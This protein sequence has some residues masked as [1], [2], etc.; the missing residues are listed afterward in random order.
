MT[1]PL[2]MRVWM[3]LAAAIAAAL[4]PTPAVAQG[5]PP[6]D[7]LPGQVIVRYEA[8][9]SKAER[10]DA[11]E[12]S[13]TEAIAGL[14]MP[15][16]QLV[17]ITD[18][19]S[20]AATL[21]QLEAQPG[22]AY[23]EPN[24]LSRPA[25]LP[26]DPEFLNGNQ[27]GLFNDGQTVNGEPG[28]PNADIS[29][30]AAWNLTTGVSS[31][32]VAVMDTGA[33]LQHPDLVDE[34]WT[35]P[36][37]GITHGHDFIGDGYN[38]TPGSINPDSDPRDLDGHGT[39]VSGIALA[40][41]NN[42][43]GITGVS[44]RAALMSLRICGAYD[45]GCPDSALVQAINYA[46]DHGARVVNGS[47]AG[48]VPNLAVSDALESH[49]GTLYVFA[50]GNGDTSGNGVN[51]DLVPNYPCNSDQGPGYAA[52][53]VICVAATDQSDRRADFSNYGASAVDLGAPGVNIFSA[54]SQRAFLSDDFESG[55]GQWTNT[56]G[57][58]WSLVNEAPLNQPP[59]T[60]ANNGVSD[61]PGGDYAAGV[62]NEVT[63][64]AVT[65]P[66]GYSS[67]RLDYW[68]SVQ[69]ATGDQF[70]I[71]VLLDGQV[72]ESATPA[73]NTARDGWFDLNPDFDAGGQVQV[74]LR[75]TSDSIPATVDDGVHMDNVKLTCHGSPSDNGYVFMRGTSM[76][77]PMVSGAAALLFS[78][79]PSSEASDVKGQLLATVDPLSDL[80]GETA[81]GGRLNVY[82]ALASGSS[83]PSDGGGGDG[84]GGGS[85][86]TFAPSGSSNLNKRPN[87]F[88]K[89]KPRRVVRTDAA[90][91]R[92]VFRFGAT[93]PG[94]GFRC[95]LDRA[96]YAPCA[97]RFARR[98]ALGRH[99][100][101]VRAV[102]SA[103]LMDP[104]PAVAR[105]RVE[106]DE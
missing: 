77:A 43:I 9:S 17:K 54:S 47:I 10:A 57:P 102:S 83:N 69:T 31:T 70:T 51:N 2:R 68:R 52:E 45:S 39:H 65:L 22:V 13:G 48:G 30:T 6:G 78:R 8:H 7:F 46:G 19:D 100:L 63:S 98:L 93:E 103:G 97:K 27:W 34:L 24:G 99:V 105:V 88:F 87:T 16:A 101:K 49:P 95:R 26:N 18:G 90:R 71:E 81:S 14:G 72:K 76:A 84:D 25:L 11:R 66:A 55:F 21:R 91:T 67:C 62:A 23:A 3:P 50:A 89:R 64:N 15:R 29:A 80:A 106:L 36:D 79:Y 41:G 1:R 44:Q 20:V 40:E 94:S 38:G 104:T 42:G 53:N 28:V 5:L 60:T 61:S 37:D 73:N 58:G 82:A 75:L 35:N 12:D 85:A 59:F 86:P 32:V 4:L 33:E 92:V 56:G 74:R 96:A